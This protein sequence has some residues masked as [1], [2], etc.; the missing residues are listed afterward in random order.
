M[1]NFD[2]FDL[3]PN[4][5]EPYGNHALTQ[6]LM[7]ARMTGY[8][9]RNRAEYSEAVPATNTVYLDQSRPTQ[10]ILPVTSGPP[11]Q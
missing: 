3:N 8:V 4:T 9:P 11:S 2:R 6:E 1:A 7:S 10:V 5:G